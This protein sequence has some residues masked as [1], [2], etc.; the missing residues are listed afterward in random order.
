MANWIAA[1]TQLKLVSRESARKIVD[2]RREAC[3]NYLVAADI[4]LDQARELAYRMENSLAEPERAAAHDVYFDGWNSLIGAHATVVVAG[5]K[6]LGDSAAAL[7][8]KLASV[9][10][11]CEAWYRAYE[12]GKTRNRSSEFENAQDEVFKARDSFVLAAQGNFED[13]VRMLGKG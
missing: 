3:V 9:G 5:P 6:P 7:Q 11:I 10:G 12:S 4:F 8:D 1:R 2:T 13:D